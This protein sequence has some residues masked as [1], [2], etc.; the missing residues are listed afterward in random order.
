MQSQMLSAAPAPA[1]RL[2]PM[3]DVDGQRYCRHCE[4]TLPVTMFPGG[5]RKY[6]CRK[7]VWLCITKPSKTRLMK[8]ARKKM[9]WLIWKRAWTDAK[10]VFMQDRVCIVQADIEAAIALLPADVD[11]GAMCVVPADP[12]GPVSK[13]NVE[14]VHRNARRQLMRAYRTGGA[15]QYARHL[16]EICEAGH[17]A[18]EATQEPARA[19]ALAP[20]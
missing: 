13:E 14:L 19:P 9:L 8:D 16:V 17:D 2:P 6:I 10:S 18:R 7:H 3:P 20:P 5:R 4:A 1:A 11:A 15:A 12:T